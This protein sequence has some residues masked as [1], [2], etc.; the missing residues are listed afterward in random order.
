MYEVYYF[1]AATSSWVRYDINLGPL[2]RTVT[3]SR[4]ARIAR[5]LRGDG[6]DVKISEVSP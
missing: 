6:F 1:D 4:A 3:A 2:E 5:Q